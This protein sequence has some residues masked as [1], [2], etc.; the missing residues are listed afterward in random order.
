MLLQLPA[1]TLFKYL[2][3][4]HT[5]AVGLLTD[6]VMA[7][8]AWLAGRRRSLRLLILMQFF[9]GAGQVRS[10]PRVWQRRSLGE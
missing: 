6:T 10:P 9:G 7:L 3:P 2:G 5:I 4:R 8:G 1:G